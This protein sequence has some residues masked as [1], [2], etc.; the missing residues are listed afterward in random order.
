[1]CKHPHA[2]MR[3][4]VSWAG[5]ETAA[6]C[7]PPARCL[8]KLQEQ[9]CA[10]PQHPPIPSA[11][12]NGNAGSPRFSSHRGTGWQN[13]RLQL[14]QVNP[15]AKGKSKE[16]REGETPNPTRARAR[17]FC[18]V[19]GNELQLT[20]LNHSKKNPVMP[21]FTTCTVFKILCLLL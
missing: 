18:L 17:L 1:M 7:G 8:C 4:P 5:E 13:T 9:P 14:V 11:Q 21:I 3:C 15:D 19:H 6:D 12:Q 2:K 16:K 20:H 10:I